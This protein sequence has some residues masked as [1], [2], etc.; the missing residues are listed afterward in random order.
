MIFV[1]LNLNFNWNRNLP[2]ISIVGYLTKQKE[3]YF[4]YPK[5]DKTYYLVKM[6]LV[7]KIE[8]TNYC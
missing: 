6:N 8:I 5:C 7:S 1:I 3:T 2:T 4:A